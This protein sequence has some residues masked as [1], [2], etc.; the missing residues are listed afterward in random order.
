MK[1]GC[2][3]RQVN[4]GLIRY[5]REHMED[6]DLTPA[7]CRMLKYLLSQNKKEYCLTDICMEAKVSKA[8]GSVILKALREKGYLQ[9]NSDSEDDR[10][11]KVVLTQKAYEMQDIIEEGLKR[12]SACIYKGISDKELYEL[13][14][15]L[16]KMI[17]NLKQTVES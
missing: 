16:N 12:S 5:G 15:T 4:A 10:K 14:N 11:R 9:V 7:Q 2:L 17:M 13:E 6:L 3:L 1:I 8:T